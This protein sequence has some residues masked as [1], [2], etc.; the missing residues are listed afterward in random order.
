MYSPPFNRIDDR[1]KIEEFVHAHG[2]ATL[3]TKNSE[4]LCASHLPVLFDEAAGRIGVLRSHMARA[5]GQWRHFA[6]GDEVLCIFPG[7][8]AYISPSCYVTQHTVPTWNYATVHVY[9]VPTIVDE[10]ALKEIV[11]E[12]TSKYEATMAAPWTIPLS[13]EELDAMLKAIV[14]FS[15]AVT[16]IEAKFKLGQNRSREDQESMLLALQTAPDS[17]S[18][19]LAEFIVRQAGS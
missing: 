2:F 14:G 18:R 10:A 9:G 19:D 17:G 7:P 12:T 8:H 6:S 1:K 13:N 5:N 3:I 16:R 4:G 11:F 15:I